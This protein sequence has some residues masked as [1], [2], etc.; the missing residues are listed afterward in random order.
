MQIVYLS[1]RPALLRETLSHVEHFAPFLDDV[2]IVGPERLASDFEGLGTVITDEA[3]T[4]RSTSELGALD[5]TSRNYLL[6]TAML[7]HEEIEAEFVMSDDD[8]RPLIPIDLGFFVDAHGR[9]RR[10]W[11]HTMGTW[12]RSATDFDMGMLN[13]WVILRQ[14]GHVDPLSYASHMPQVIDR[15]LFARVA[16]RLAPF[17]LDHPLD[18]WSTYFTLAPEMA[19]D[20]FSEPE[21]FVTLGWPQYPGEWPHQITPPMHCWENHHPEMHQPGGLYD[22][23]PTGCEPS[24]VDATSLEKILRWHRLDIDVRSL[25]FPDDVEQPW[26]GPSAGRKFAFKGLK[27]ARGAY[28]YIALDERARI[29]ELEGRL[30][31][32]EAA[33]DPGAGA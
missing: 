11:F 15:E 7:G 29:A 9:H 18:E 10:R 27:A 3:L 32:L 16:E 28:R 33:Y 23:L 13:T 14:L 20:R 4:G 21:P 2:V 24:T 8:S 6:R 12:R 26:T 30:Q 17:A 19:P 31:R 5:H 25:N 22:G 1:A